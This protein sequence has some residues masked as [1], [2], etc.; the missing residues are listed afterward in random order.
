MTEIN[1]H[2]D[3]RQYED[4]LRAPCSFNILVFKIRNSVRFVSIIPFSRSSF[5]VR[6]RVSGLVPM[7]WAISI[8]VRGIVIVEPSWSSPS[9][10]EKMFRRNAAVLWATES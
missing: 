9:T 3:S 2:I 5:N 4:R 7:I 1:I 6:E 10:L 8:L